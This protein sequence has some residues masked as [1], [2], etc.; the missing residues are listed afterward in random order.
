MGHTL[1]GESTWKKKGKGRK[2]KLKLVDRLT[3]EECI[4]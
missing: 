2:L 4:K 3:V 1:R